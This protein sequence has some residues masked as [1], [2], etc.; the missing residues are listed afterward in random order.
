MSSEIAVL[1]IVSAMWTSWMC[2][3]IKIGESK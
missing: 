3:V 1:L 2:V